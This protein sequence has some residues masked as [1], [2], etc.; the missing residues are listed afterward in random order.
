MRPTLLNA[1]KTA[2]EFTLLL[3]PPRTLYH[4]LLTQQ[5]TYEYALHTVLITAVLS[6]VWPLPST[7]NNAEALLAPSRGSE[8][9]FEVYLKE[10]SSS[11]GSEGR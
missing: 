9:N 4:T 10:D 5:H 1:G 6:Y 8:L 7:T 11:G 3:I 2:L